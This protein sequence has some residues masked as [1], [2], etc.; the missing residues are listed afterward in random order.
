MKPVA[1]EDD[2]IAR[3]LAWRENIADLD[4]WIGNSLPGIESLD[5][6]VPSG[7]CRAAW[8]Y[9]IFELAIRPDRTDSAAL[10]DVLGSELVARSLCDDSI[11]VGPFVLGPLGVITL[12]RSSWGGSTAFVDFDSYASWAE[13]TARGSLS[14]MFIRDFD[15][16]GGL[17]GWSESWQSWCL[18]QGLFEQ[19]NRDLH[20]YSKQRYRW[21]PSEAT[22]GGSFL[23]ASPFDLW[24]RAD[25]DSRVQSRLL[26]LCINQFPALFFEGIDYSRAPRAGVAIRDAG[27]RAELSNEEAW[28]LLHAVPEEMLVALAR[29]CGLIGVL[30]HRVQRDCFA[31]NLAQ[32]LVAACDR[33]GDR[34]SLRPFLGHAGGTE[35]DRVLHYVLRRGPSAVLREHVGVNIPM[36]VALAQMTAAP[37]R[38]HREASWDPTSDQEQA[39][40]INSIAEV[41]GAER[42]PDLDVRA[43]PIDGSGVAEAP[44]VIESWVMHG[45][46]R[47]EW[48][49][50]TSA[51][52]LH[53]LL[54]AF[55]E[56]HARTR[57]ISGIRKFRHYSE[58]AELKAWAEG[59]ELDLRRL[60]LSGLIDLMQHLRGKVSADAPGHLRDVADAHERLIKWY[61]Q[62]DVAK[63]GNLGAHAN[64][65]TAGELS[66]A[67]N[68]LRG[69]DAFARSTRNALPGF[70]RFVE[71]GRKV[72]YPLQVKVE[73][74]EEL[75]IAL[76][77]TE[78]FFSDFGAHFR[79]DRVLSFTDVT[80][81][82]ISVNPIVIDWTEWL[83]AVREPALRA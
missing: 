8:R 21:A 73:P 36:A 67:F 70:A 16:T 83:A 66:D 46:K 65:S 47:T 19:A 2:P 29:E 7:D 31:V 57:A 40:L 35:E 45:R 5:R 18:L 32:S 13:E 25:A 54:V 61:G 39:L 53:Q 38:F 60:T 62:N 20:I 48:I 41:L 52:Y 82:H 69:F 50:Q 22:P 78:H 51:Q 12:P 23:P 37:R 26:E 34:S 24:Y 30:E 77:K 74:I 49:L 44:H 55:A 63:S 28:Q 15:V 43:R 56:S 76:G 75:G 64:R 3:V 14:G 42:L 6:R 71:E 72:D 81:N 27:V 9:R 80:R 17:A 1:L 58:D 10:L 79:G 33:L 4:D 59:R 11:A 68:A